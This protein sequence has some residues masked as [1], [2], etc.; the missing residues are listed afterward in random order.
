MSGMVIVGAGLAGLT[1]AESLRSEG[2]EGP[3]TLVGAETQAPY[4]RPPLSKAFLLGEAKEAQLAMRPAELYA[5]KGIELRL[6]AEA[7]AIDRPARQVRFADGSALDY[8]GLALCTGARLRPLP[9]PGAEWQGVFGLRTLDDARALAAA[10]DE[11]R[12]VVVL[13]GGFIGLEVAAV[14]ARK[15]KNVVVLEAMDRLMARVVAPPVSDFYREL[16]ASRGVDVVLGAAVSELIGDAGRIAAVRT[17]DGR[18]FAADLLLVGIG[19]LPNA[20]LAAAAGLAVDG[21]IVV[22]ACSRTSDAL[23]VA[24]G[25]CAARRLAEGGLRRLE[26]V[27]NALEQAKSAAA[28]L[29]GRERPFDATPWFWSEQYDVKLQMAGLTAGYE[30]TVIRGNP[31]ARSF[32]VYY[33]RGGRLIAVDSLNQPGD[34]M[35]AR[36]LLDR[37]LSPTAEQ[38]ADPATDLAALLA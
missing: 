32:S 5:K 8:Q 19:I 25:D 11:A 38:A 26:S 12:N 24:A 31:A 28:A 10:L 35:T 7:A 36:K 3:I 33:Y 20:E 4:Q 37:Q 27:Q 6:G 21:G 14:A 34:H 30:R 17:R 9:L 16:H 2:Y 29:L 23:V 1:V 22:D 15:Q 13:G 18:E